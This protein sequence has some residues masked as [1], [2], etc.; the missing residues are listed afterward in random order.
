MLDATGSILYVEAIT[1]AFQ[2]KGI[3]VTETCF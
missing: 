2:E 1:L 3:S